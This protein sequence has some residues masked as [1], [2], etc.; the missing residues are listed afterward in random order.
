MDLDRVFSIKYSRVLEQ[1]GVEEVV[2]SVFS[3]ARP[4]QADEGTAG[5][6]FG[7]QR[8]HARKKTR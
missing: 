5:T 1:G 8:K 2:G 3:V 7:H 6:G 4:S